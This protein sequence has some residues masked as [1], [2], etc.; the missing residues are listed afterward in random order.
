M[1]GRR[2]LEEVPGQLFGQEAVVGHVPVEG[3]D[4]PVAP[5]PG[6]SASVDGIPVGVGITGGVEPGKGHLFSKVRGVE[7]SFD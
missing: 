5:E 6:I 3:L 1:L 2:I 4:D 7:Q